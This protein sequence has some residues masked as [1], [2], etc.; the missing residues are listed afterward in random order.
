MSR[1]AVS[2]VLSASAIAIHLERIASALER[3]SMRPNGLDVRRVFLSHPSDQLLSS[4]RTRPLTLP[5]TEQLF[6]R[7]SLASVQFRSGRL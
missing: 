3:L 2:Q 1:T 7:E 6:W 5:P 4:R